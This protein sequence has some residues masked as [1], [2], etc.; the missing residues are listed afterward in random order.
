M[1]WM[2]EAISTFESISSLAK[3]RVSVFEQAFPF[4]LHSTSKSANDVLSATFQIKLNL[5]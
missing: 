4:S 3:Q 1:S 2:S 5:D